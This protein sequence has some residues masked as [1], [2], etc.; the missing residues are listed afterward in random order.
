REYKHEVPIVGLIGLWMFEDDARDF[1]GEN[2][3]VLSS[4]A[5][6]DGGNLV[7][8]G[9]SN[10]G[11]GSDLRPTVITAMTW[12]K[13][14]DD[15]G[16]RN[17]VSQY[18][19]GSQTWILRTAQSGIGNFRPH[20]WTGTWYSCDGG[21]LPLNEWSHIALTYD[22]DV[23]RAYVNGVFV[24]ENTGPS[25]NLVINGPT[26]IGSNAGPG[27]YFKGSIDDV[28]IFDRALLPEEVSKIYEARKK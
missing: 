21:I 15:Q 13:P 11:L 19:G 28:M 18:G 22:G 17:P 4:G 23:M 26:I 12:V 14:T 5:V 3:G 2:D 16:V 6:I 24:C 1:E 9:N 25:G 7:L 10:V 8:D 20:I 27:E